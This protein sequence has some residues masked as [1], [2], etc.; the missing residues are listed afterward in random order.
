VNVVVFQTRISGWL[1]WY[2]MPTIP[3]MEQIRNTSAN[4][5]LVREEI[6]NA[7]F[8]CTFLILDLFGVWAL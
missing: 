2:L 6:I 8:K 1:A 7:D 5:R 4:W 3:I